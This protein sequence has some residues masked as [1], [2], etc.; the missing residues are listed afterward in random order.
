M[1]GGGPLIID[2]HIHLWPASEIKSLGWKLPKRLK[3]IDEEVAGQCSVDAW[4]HAA[5]HEF[6]CH[7]PIDE[8]YEVQGYIVIEADRESHLDAESGW[9]MPLLEVDFFRRVALGLPREGE[10]HEARDAP[11]CLGIISWAPVLLGADGLE[12]FVRK[13]RVVVGE[14]VFKNKIK[15]FRYLLQNKPRGTMLEKKFIEG[16]KWLGQ[17][18]FTFDL[19]IDVRGKG[20]W[21]MEEAVEMVRRSREGVEEDKVLKIIIDRMGKPNRRVDSTRPSFKRW[22]DQI[23]KLASFDNTY[24]KLCGAFS[25]LP[26]QNLEKLGSAS[27]VMEKMKDWLDVIFKAFKPERIMFG[28]DWPLCD[29]NLPYDEYISAWAYWKIIIEL[30]MEQEFT[31]SD[32]GEEEEEAKDG[33]ENEEVEGKSASAITAN[34]D[35]DDD[36][37]DLVETVIKPREQ[38]DVWQGTAKRVYGIILPPENQHKN[39]KGS[40]ESDDES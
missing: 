12:K 1:W 4:T 21:Q 5:A 16:L 29:I 30:Y 37:E 34:N 11:L 9:D 3:E 36:Y 7:T 17:Q 40:E 31:P 39:G 28:S 6:D 19:A 15:G 8:A 13:V 23:N 35:D 18:G 26:N 32:E 2:S 27:D 14:D 20:I 24:M 22:Q 33:K 38:D 10:G 25:E